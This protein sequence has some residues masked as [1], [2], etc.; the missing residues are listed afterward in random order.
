MLIQN[1]RIIT[2]D[3]ENRVIDSGAVE[4]RAG[5]FGSVGRERAA[6]GDSDV[7]SDVIDAR[8]KV[9]MPA[10]INCHTHLYSTL[11]RGIPLSGPA[12]RSFPEILRKLWWRL[13]QAL[14]EEDVYYSAFVGLIDSAKAGVGTLVDH[15]SS[16]NACPGSLDRIAAAC[17]EVGMRGCLC[18]ETTDRNGAAKAKEGMAENVRFIERLR[19]VPDPLLG[20]SFGLHASFTLNKGTL[21]RCAE[22]GRALGCGFHVHVAEDRSDVLDARR[23]SGKTPVGRLVAAGALDSRSLA[24][25]CIHVTAGDVRSLAAQ[26]VSVVHNPQ[27]NCNNAVGVARLR[28]L[29]R[30]G[31]LV[32]L[33]SDGYSPRLAEEFK[34]SYHLQKLRGSPQAA[35]DGY[36]VAFLNNRQIVEK[37]WGLKLGRIAEGAPADFVLVD[38]D[39]PTPLDAGN[40]FGHLLFGIAHAPVDSLVVNGRFVLRDKRCVNV[41]EAAIAEKA[42]KQARRLWQRF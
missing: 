28:D 25:H 15:H 18:Y 16:P 4:V 12:P 8:G 30:A 6:A 39:P 14:N 29:L 21:A 2:F 7:D 23:R 24:A 5:V 42:R 36:A 34:T 10:L 19:R 32:G 11:A 38:Y 13:D 40:L 27:S 35:L 17:R 26:R 31:V 9:L 37:I 41:D 1:A 20:A 33:G 22:A 3:G